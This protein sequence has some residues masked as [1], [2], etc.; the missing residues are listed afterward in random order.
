MSVEVKV[1]DLA[2]YG[3]GVQWHDLDNS[4]VTGAYVV[5]PG[6][7]VRFSDG[8]CWYLSA[9]KHTR[10]DATR[11]RHVMH[12]VHTV[13]CARTTSHSTLDFNILIRYG[14]M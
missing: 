3:P 13:M 1:S 8:V 7:V 4:S 6:T 10:S 12:A 11:A 2:R 5:D 14:W 9:P